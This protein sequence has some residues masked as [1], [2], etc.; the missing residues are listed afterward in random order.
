MVWMYL[1]ATVILLGAAYNAER[2]TE[3]SPPPTKE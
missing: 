2:L 1:C 3:K